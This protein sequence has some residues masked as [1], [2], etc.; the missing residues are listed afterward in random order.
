MDGMTPVAPPNMLRSFARAKM[1]FGN[2][3]AVWPFSVACSSGL[4]DAIIRLKARFF[5]DVVFL[6][7]LAEDWFD[8]VVVVDKAVELPGACGTAGGTTGP[9]WMASSSNEDADAPCDKEGTMAV[10][11][12]EISS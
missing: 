10:R 5:C 1:S 7:R 2:A 12:V 11:S 8:V 4:S 9:G 3:L 6:R